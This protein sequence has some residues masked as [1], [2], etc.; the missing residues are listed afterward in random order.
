MLHLEKLLINQQHKTQILKVAAQD[1]IKKLQAQA[2]HQSYASE[3]A[4]AKLQT[5]LK[6]GLTSQHVKEVSSVN[7]N[8]TNK[9][10]SGERENANEAP[11]GSKTKN[12]KNGS[13]PSENEKQSDT[14]KQEKVQN[15][16]GNIEHHASDGSHSWVGKCCIKFW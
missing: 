1:T 14:K 11:K 2:N 16:G 12:E 15:G 9:P 10:L 5:N 6:A 4:H 8:D 7:V 13:N 3:Q